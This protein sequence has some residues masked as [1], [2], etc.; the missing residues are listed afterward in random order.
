MGIP[1]PDQ[2]GYMLR[3]AATDAGRAYKERWAEYPERGK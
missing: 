3:T 1:R 2:A